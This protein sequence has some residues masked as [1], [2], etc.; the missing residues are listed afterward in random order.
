VVAEVRTNY[1]ADQQL[2][3][4]SILHVPDQKLRDFSVHQRFIL[5]MD[6]EQA[7]CI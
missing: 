3:H 1:L 2:I 4:S 5:A 6:T 7:M